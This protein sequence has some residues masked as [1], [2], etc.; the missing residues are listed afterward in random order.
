MALPFTSEQFLDVFRQYNTSIWPLQCLL[1]AI[2]LIAVVFAV[3]GR[4]GRVVAF[5]LAGQWAWTGIVYH[6][7]FFAKI[8][9]AAW[10][11]GTLWLAGAMAFARNGLGNRVL[12]GQAGGAQ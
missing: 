10:F 12:S 6:W 1:T 7:L 9:P 4:R 2:A 5:C 8:N 11:F 3:R